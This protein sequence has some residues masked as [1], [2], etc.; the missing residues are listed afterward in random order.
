MAI[1][2]T[3][4]GQTKQSPLRQLTRDKHLAIIYLFAACDGAIKPSHILKMFLALNAQN[5]LQTSAILSF[6]QQFI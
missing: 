1:H 3:L 6:L 5:L 2:I 4:V